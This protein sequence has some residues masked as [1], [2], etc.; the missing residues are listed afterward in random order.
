MLTNTR[1]V[2]SVKNLILYYMLSDKNCVYKPKA[3]LNKKLCKLVGTR[4]NESGAVTANI[5]EWK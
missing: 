1:N 3:V 4:G 2:N 5:A